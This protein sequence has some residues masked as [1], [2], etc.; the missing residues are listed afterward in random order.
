MGIVGKATACHEV[1]TETQELSV[2][3]RPR[4]NIKKKSS[5][6][7]PLNLLLFF[8]LLVGKK[9][10]MDHPD[11]PMSNHFRTD[12]DLIPERVHLTLC[13]MGYRDRRIP[14][15]PFP[16]PTQMV[17]VFLNLYQVFNDPN[18]TLMLVVSPTLIHPHPNPNPNP[19]PI[20]NLTVSVLH[21]VPNP[22][23]NEV[24]DRNQERYEGTA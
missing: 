11:F 12:H 19:L 18:L 6:P 23:L 3:E 4:K 9:K 14:E 13:G 24:P 17:N 22:N 16:E 5:S 2:P 20:P 7:R 15:N 10:K 1:W 21:P 8:L